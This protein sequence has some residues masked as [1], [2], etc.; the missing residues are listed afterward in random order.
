MRQKIEASELI[1]IRETVAKCPYCGKS[2]YVQADSWKQRADGTWAAD[3]ISIDCDG[4]PEIDSPE[5]D[6]WDRGHWYMPYVY[7]LPVHEKVLAWLNERYDF[8]MGEDG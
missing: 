7:L 5:W 3:H 6:E 8:E 4:E 2:L 1:C